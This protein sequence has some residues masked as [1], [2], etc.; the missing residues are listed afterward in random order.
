MQRTELSAKP[1]KA[2]SQSK[3]KIFSRDK[4]CFFG[5]HHE[6]EIQIKHLQGMIRPVRL[7]PQPLSYASY[8][9]MRGCGRFR[10]VMIMKFGWIFTPWPIGSYRFLSGRRWSLEMIWMK[11]AVC[12]WEGFL[13]CQQAAVSCETNVDHFVMEQRGPVE[14]CAWAYTKGLSYTVFRGVL[15]H[16]IHDKKD[17]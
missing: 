14:S 16:Q 3:S 17:L 8:R 4:K 1:P 7:K 2:V 15:G 12:C 6:T 10:A 5:N 11:C 9:R 13:H